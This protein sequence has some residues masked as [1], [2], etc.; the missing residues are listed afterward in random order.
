MSTYE[1]EVQII[2]FD[3]SDKKTYYA[4]YSCNL[5][6]GIDKQESVAYDASACTPYCVSDSFNTECRRIDTCSLIVD[7]G[8]KRDT[9]VYEWDS[10]SES[11]VIPPPICVSSGK[12]TPYSCSDSESGSSSESDSSCCGSSLSPCV[13]RSRMFPTTCCDAKP[14]TCPKCNNP[15]MLSSYSRFGNNLPIY[16]KLAPIE[17]ALKKIND[18]LDA[19]DKRLMTVEFTPPSSGGP[20]FHRLM[21][22]AKEAGDF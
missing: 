10:T 15:V 4:C 1:K 14:I 5:I 22:E 9:S 19:L 11:D 16:A 12:I 18:R 21:G 3:L 13:S 17:E 8:S 6:I 2:P 7:S 20:E